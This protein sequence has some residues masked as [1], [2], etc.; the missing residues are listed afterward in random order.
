MQSIRSEDKA[1]VLNYSAIRSC[2]FACGG[3]EPDIRLLLSL[4]LQRERF[5]HRVLRQ[6]HVI[7]DACG[8][9]RRAHE[10]FVKVGATIHLANG[11]QTECLT[12]LHAARMAEVCDVVSL[13]VTDSG[14][15][16][17]VRHM[18][19][20]GARVELYGVW[21]SDDSLFPAA[22]EVI[23]V[24]PVPGAPLMPPPGAAIAA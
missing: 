10:E 20:L 24:H 4:H 21:N 3:E 8:L 7:V 18:K 23:A 11:L 16:P 13:F 14:Y 15:L 6:I 12:F 9:P 2:V 1:I 22:D 19:S 17:L 5:P